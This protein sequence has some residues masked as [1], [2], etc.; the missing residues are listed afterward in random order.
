MVSPEARLADAL[1]EGSL[2]AA[3][4]ILEGIHD[5]RAHRPPAATGAEARREAL[6]DLVYALAQAQAQALQQ[7]LGLGAAA[8]P[9][10]RAALGVAPA[11]HALRFRPPGV[12][13]QR[14]VVRNASASAAALTVE[15]G[16]FVSDA[17]HLLDHD[18]AVTVAGAPLAP[19]EDAPERRRLVTAPAA[20]AA[21]ASA[22]VELTV[23]T[24]AQATPGVV[25]RS[26]LT[27]SIA[28]AA[29]RAVDLELTLDGR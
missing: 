14:L 4:R 3:A 12:A 19:V 21:G 7:A 17:G 24:A 26:V 16:A 8:A 15:H 6:G 1:R 25:Y 20:V 2:D 27:L 13:R 18:L 10:L 29:P 5:A 9:A 23:G 11:R 28:G 22:L